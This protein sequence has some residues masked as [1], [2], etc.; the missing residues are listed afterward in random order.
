MRPVSQQLT[1]ETAR[2]IL[3]YAFPKQKIAS[4]ELLT[5]GLINTNFKV[6]FE[7][8]HLPVVL[9]LYRDGADVCRKEVALHK[10]VQAEIPVPEMIHNETD[11]PDGLPPFAVFEFINGITFQQ[12]KRTGDVDAI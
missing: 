6:Q 7:S 11:N 3:S 12:L 2:E 9:R 4:T 8:Y 10:L 5:G 1:N